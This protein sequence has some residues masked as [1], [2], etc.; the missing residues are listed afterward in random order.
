MLYIIIIDKL[1]RILNIRIL[2]LEETCI[3]KE[4][5]NYIN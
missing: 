3:N 5:I 4:I 2:R 1:I